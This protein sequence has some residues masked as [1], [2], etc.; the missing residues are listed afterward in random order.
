MKANLHPWR[1]LCNDD[2]WFD[3]SALKALE[4]IAVIDYREAEYA[5]LEKVIRHYDAYFASASVRADKNILQNAHQLK[6]IATP[7]TGTDHIDVQ[8]AKSNG[9]KILDLS[10]EYDV[11]DTFSATAEHAWCLI[12]ALLRRLPSAF[13]SAKAGCWARQAYAGTQ[14]LGKTLGII[15]FGRLGK[16]MAA[17]AAGFRMK[18]IACDTKPIAGDFVRQVDLETLLAESDIVSIHVHLTEGTRGLIGRKELALMKPQS[19]IINTSRGAVIDESALL[20]ALENGALS[21]AAL[22]VI[23][24]EWDMDL[25]RHP[26]IAYA[27]EHDNLIITPHIGGSTIESIVGA[28]VYMA[29]QLKD[30]LLSCDNLSRA[31]ND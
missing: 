3:R 16:M 10:R 14:V 30:Y 18:I 4:E 19:I 22:D 9:I 27:R 28:R 29:Q 24:G 15:G 11:L 31:A 6:V 2:L 26:L 20:T 12:L 8:Y 25:T 17:M 7:S 23:C 1:I 5:L 13:A 21:G